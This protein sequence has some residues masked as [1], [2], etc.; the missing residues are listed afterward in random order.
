MKT[1]SQCCIAL[2]LSIDCSLA[3]AVPAVDLTITVRADDVLVS[4]RR[5]DNTD[6]LERHVMSAAPHVVRVQACGPSALTA[7][8]V[9]VYR[10]RRLPIEPAV[11]GAND[12]AC[13]AE[14]LATPVSLTTR[15]SLL[16][17]ADDAAV[18]RFWQQMM[19]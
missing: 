10:L 3:L 2:L 19:P 11:I 4:G 17:G 18:N 12:P 9:V 8:K 1:V 13:V 16:D 5:F 7:W 6:A 15:G 14:T